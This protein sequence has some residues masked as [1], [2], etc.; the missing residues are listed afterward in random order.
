M[1]G[2]EPGEQQ[3]LFELLVHDLTG[4]LA[5]IAAS[6][7]RLLQQSTG[8]EQPVLRRIL[9]NA[10]RSQILLDDLLE[11]LHSDAGLFRPEAFS[12]EA[13]LRE[14]VLGVLEI[15]AREE[16]DALARQERMREFFAMLE[17][18]CIFVQ[19]SGRY[20][21]VPFRH[22][23]RKIQ[24]IIRNLLSNALK[25]KRQR[26]DVKIG[27][28]T[29]LLVSVADDGPG[30]APDDQE[31]VFR[32][33]VRLKA[34]DASAPGLGLGLAGVKAL[35][36]AMGGKITLVSQEGAGAAFSVNIPPLE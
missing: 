8:P 33:F 18:Y 21:R 16:V 1:P 4:P 26:V 3:R 22:D 15:D 9:R 5:V 35:V 6:A 31:A 24:Q 2:Q 30:I 34:A 11:I 12:V 25:H 28:E 27:G 23:P 19:V 7:A 17:P 13:I 36:E 20:D 29:D 32:R 10:R 14:S